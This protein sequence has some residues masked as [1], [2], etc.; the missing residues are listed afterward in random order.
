MPAFQ[1][2]AGLG[3]WTWT[4]APPAEEAFFENP[5]DSLSLGDSVATFITGPNKAWQEDPSFHLELW[6]WTWIAKP[7]AAGA[8]LTKEVSD[9]LTLG[10]TRS[11][12]A[13]FVRSTADALALAELLAKVA[14]FVRNPSDPLTLSA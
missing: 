9:G 14:A 3:F 6:G 2:D 12:A 11:G 1:D 13:G 8:T 4:C 7:A 10:D 5:S